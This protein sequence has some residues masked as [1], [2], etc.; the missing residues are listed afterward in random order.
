MTG[1]A[2]GRAFFTV[3]LLAVAVLAFTVEDVLSFPEFLFLEILVVTTVALKPAFA[4]HGADCF[5]G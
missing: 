2:S 1:T 4:V 5:S 3:D